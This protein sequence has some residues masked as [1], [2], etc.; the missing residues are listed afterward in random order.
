MP[1]SYL[2]PADGSK[3]T[4]IEKCLVGM[5]YVQYA[6]DHTLSVFKSLYV[7]EDL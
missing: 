6:S 1:C 4:G 3:E 5:F 2:E 7:E